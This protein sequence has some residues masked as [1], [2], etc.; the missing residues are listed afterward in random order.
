L[1][2][3]QDV[4]VVIPQAVIPHLPAMTWGDFLYRE[5]IPFDRENNSF[6]DNEVDRIA[7]ENMDLI[8]R[9]SKFAVAMK[10]RSKMDALADLVAA[11][12]SSG[13]VGNKDGDWSWWLY[14]RL[15]RVLDNDNE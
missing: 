14:E 13:W 5:D 3:D 2:V 8:E 10:E 12:V 4:D 15:A 6:S 1:E 9:V 7:D 11:S